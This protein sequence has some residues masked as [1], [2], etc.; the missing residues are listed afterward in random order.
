MRKIGTATVC[1]LILCILFSSPK[2]LT[3]GAHSQVDTAP[4]III[5][6]PT[7]NTVFTVEHVEEVSFYLKYQTNITLSWV[8]YSLDGAKNV[9]VMGNDTYYHDLEADG[10]HNLTLYANDTAGNWAT[11]QTV[12]YLTHN[13]SGALNLIPTILLFT[14]VLLVVLV[15]LVTLLLLLRRHRKIKST[16]T[17]TITK[18][19]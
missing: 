3:K 18:Q 11:P 5:L 2:L 10:Y 17:T 1:L 8:G 6:Y 16:K 4:S 14:V 12:I 15:T 7:N 19:T 13:L 9:T